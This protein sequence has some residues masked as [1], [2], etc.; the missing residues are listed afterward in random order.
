MIS[1]YNV[2]LNVKII[3]IYMKI[4][5]VWRILKIV[6]NIKIIHAFNVIKITNKYTQ[7][8]MIYIVFKITYN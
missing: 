1:K 8:I 6:K 5:F 4:N 3:I 7:V 2:F